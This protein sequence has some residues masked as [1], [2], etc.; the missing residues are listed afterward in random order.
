[1]VDREFNLEL[2]IF[3][4]TDGI[5]KEKTELPARLIITST[6]SKHLSSIFLDFGSHK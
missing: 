1:M 3:L 2:I 6:S 5:H 4:F